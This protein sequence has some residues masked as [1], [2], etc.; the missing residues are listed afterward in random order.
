MWRRSRVRKEGLDKMR[1]EILR[2]RLG[3]REEEISEFEK[4]KRRTKESKTRN[5][6]LQDLDDGGGTINDGVKDIQDGAGQYTRRAEDTNGER[7]NIYTCH[8]HLRTRRRS[9]FSKKI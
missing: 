7:E 3:E 8:R 4:Y 5:G 9:T 1:H 6:G 2:A